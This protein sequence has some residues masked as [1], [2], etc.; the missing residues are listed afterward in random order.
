MKKRIN[1]KKLLKNKTFILFAILFVAFL[2]ILILLWK[3]FFPGGGSNYGNR[4]DGIEKISF[5]EKAQKSITSSIKEHEKVNSSK[6]L[7]HGKIINV[8]F[9]VK[10]DTTL[11][12]AK[13]IAV[14]SLEKFSKKVKGF[15][16]I[17]FMIT[18]NKEKGEEVEVTK[19]DGTTAKE[20]K[21][22]FPIMGYKKA[23]R[24]SIV[25]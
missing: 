2:I 11:D 21:K 23:S 22:Q 19:E 18:K 9:D 13:A 1:F 14:V 24:D 10:E 17:E 25:W 20:I 8:I 12:E 7:I 6:L 16:D 3:V 4:L 5:T 15:Y